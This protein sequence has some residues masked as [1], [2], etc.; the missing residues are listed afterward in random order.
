MSAPYAY[1]PR[2]YYQVQAGYGGR[3]YSN[4]GCGTVGPDADLY[5]ILGTE[6][7][8]YISNFY[9]MKAQNKKASWNWC[10]FLV[11]PYWFIYRKMY[12][13]GAAV[14]GAEF[15]QSIIG[16]VFTSLLSLA[17]YIILGIFANY[18]YMR[19]VDR[20]VT[21]LKNLTEPYR[22]EFIARNGGTNSA[23]TVLTIVGY[24]ILVIMINAG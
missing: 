21:Q 17:G 10:A 14:L 23:A 19:Q 3:A 20:N 8:Y 7:E 18:I 6:P 22:T 2:E 5:S 15:I 1:A 16:G 13:Y 4:G 9:K 24:V 12:G 11:A